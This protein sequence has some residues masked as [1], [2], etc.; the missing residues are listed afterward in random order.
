MPTIM[1]MLMILLLI[2]NK[3]PHRHPHHPLLLLLPKS[4]TT[5]RRRTRINKSTTKKL[6]VKMRCLTKK[7]RSRNPAT[8]KKLLSNQLR[9]QQVLP[10][11][12]P[13][14]SI[15]PCRCL[16]L[17]RNT[18]M[19]SIFITRHHPLHHRIVAI[20][21]RML[22]RRWQAAIRATMRRPCTLHP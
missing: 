14:L 11:Q 6:E 17:R 12:R 19:T 4:S 16:L 18:V 5:N 21:I 10:T 9:Q 8:A 20:T 7:K 3:Q 2:S 22:L 1:M 13:K 15:H